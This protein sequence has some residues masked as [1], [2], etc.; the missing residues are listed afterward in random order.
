MTKAE[1]QAFTGETKL[2][3]KT[4]LKRTFGYLKPQLPRFIT[5]LLLIV[6]NVAFD[7]A[8]PIFISSACDNLKSNS[9]NLNFIIGLAVGYVGIGAVNQVVLYAESMLLQRAGQ[10]IVANIRLEVY[11]HI[12]HLSQSQLDKCPSARW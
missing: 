10:S 12:Q 9:V 1:M 6:L 2:P 5:A 4:T 8:L 7:V 3:L 11:D